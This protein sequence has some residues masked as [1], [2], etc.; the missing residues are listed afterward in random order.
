MDQREA[1]LIVPGEHHHPIPMQSNSRLY[2]FLAVAIALVL[3][4]MGALAYVA[5]ESAQYKSGQDQANRQLQLIS[6]TAD[7]NGMI[8]SMLLDI[9]RATSLAA[10]ELKATGLNGTAARAAMDRTLQASDLI[11]D[12]VTTDM[13]G[14]IIAAQPSSYSHLEGESI[15]DQ[16]PIAFMIGAQQPVISR[17]MPM[18]EGY[19]A[20][21]I[22]YPVFDA[23]GNMTGTVTSLFRPDIMAGRAYNELAKPYG[24]S[25]MVMQRD[26]VILYDPDYAQV[27]RNTFTDPMFADYPQIKNVAWKMVNESTGIDN[28]TFT[29]PGQTTPVSK[30]VAWCT[31]YL[32]NVNWTIAVNRLA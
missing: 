11:I 13:A 6:A 26:G 5:N 32:H 4:E 12:V 23:Q 10:M 9:D 14:V 29:V 22:G 15:M 31:T 7:C 21:F 19:K 16:E 8:G 30:V 18:V 20:V 25:L 27:G 2:A 3:V 28:Y 1:T 17:L 24:L